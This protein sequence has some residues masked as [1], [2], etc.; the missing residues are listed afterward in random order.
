MS[1]YATGDT[2][3]DTLHARHGRV[4]GVVN[5]AYVNVDWSEPFGGYESAV[6]IA[7]LVIPA[8]TPERAIS[9]LRQSIGDTAERNGWTLAMARDSDIAVRGRYTVMVEYTANGSFLC[10]AVWSRTGALELSTRSAADV[11]AWLQ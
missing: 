5:D 4:V 11:L 6:P 10:G 9:A 1:Q 8:T 2:V 7:R 3:T